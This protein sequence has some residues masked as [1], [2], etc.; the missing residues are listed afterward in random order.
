MAHGTGRRGRRGRR[1]R[2]RHQ[3]LPEVSA[4]DEPQDEGQQ[5][6][7]GD[8]RGP[9]AA[10][11]GGSGFV[12]SCAPRTAAASS[13]AAHRG[14]QRLRRP[15]V[16]ALASS[17]RVC[18]AV[19]PTCGLGRLCRGTSHWRRE[20]RDKAAAQEGAGGSWLS[21]SA[22]R[23]APSTWGPAWLPA[24][25]HLS[26]TPHS[27]RPHVIL[28]NPHPHTQH[29]RAR[30]RAPPHK[31]RAQGERASRRGGLALTFGPPSP[32][33]ASG[34]VILGACASWQR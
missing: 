8:R 22:R 11:R 14:R 6:A 33:R 19:T 25:M 18:C 3:W 15:R 2:Q 24:N 20:A 23:L 34:G 30:E 32:T 16:V 7:G 26:C 10:Q 31:K 9:Q 4:D 29:T 21:A 17:T 12:A 28:A 27:P 1:R 5:R 13:Q